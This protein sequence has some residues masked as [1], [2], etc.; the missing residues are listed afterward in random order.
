VKESNPNVGKI[1]LNDINDVN[2]AKDCSMNTTKM[3]ELFD[4][5]II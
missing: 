2:M 1:Y 4:D 5:T 3:K